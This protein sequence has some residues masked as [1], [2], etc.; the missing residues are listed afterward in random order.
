MPPRIKA[1]III[2]SYNYRRY[3]SAAID[4]A[5]AQSHPHTEVIVVD[6]GSTDGSADIIQA[7]ASR[8]HAIL[9]DNGGQASAFN[10]GFRASSGEVVCF[11]DSDDVMDP[12]AVTEALERLTA[13]VVKVHWPLR[14]IDR[15]SRPTGAY[16]HRHD[17]AEGDVRDIVLRRGPAG[18]NWA[19]TSGN[20]WTRAFLERVL[21]M[22]EPEYRIGPDVYL[23]ALSPLFGSIARLPTPR[24]AYR[25]HGQNHTYREPF[26]R[27][28]AST[29]A[30][31]DHCFGVL[32]EWC[33]RLNLPARPEQ[34]REDS[35]WHETQ[36]AAEEIAES[37]PPNHVVVLAG[38]PQWATDEIAGRR[39]VP[40][41]ERENLY[42]GPPK[43]DA[44]AVEELE[45]QRR[46]G[47][48]FL[49]VPWWASWWEQQY[50][51]FWNRLGSIYQQVR[52]NRRMALF[53]LRSSSS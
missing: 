48:S 1:S 3:L 26:D 19:S 23:A 13:G 51:Q 38:E 7:Y 15:E 43:D 18:Y 39:V 35:F 53:D 40:L 14:I 37:V 5:L 50:P 20:A 42:W 36:K 8:I 6:D 32:L 22:P 21:P 10:A 4:S 41:V 33:R 27:R 28:V 16:I 47:A 12:E 31:W 29:V 34:W 17:L 44:A 30:F 24:G 49:V 46:R 11:M 45:R 25:I 2:T 9:K 52:R